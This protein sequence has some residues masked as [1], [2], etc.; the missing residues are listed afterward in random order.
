[1]TLKEYYTPESVEE[2]LGLKA[3]HGTE[4]S[5]MGGGTIFMHLVNDGYIF[6]EQ[7]MGLRRT[8]M[9]SI[10]ENGKAVIGST[11]TMTQLVNMSDDYNMLR[12]AAWS[13]G[14]WAVRNMGTIG[15]NLFARAPYGDVGVALLAL[16]AEVKVQNAGSERVVSLEAF[17]GGG[18]SLGEDELI[19]EIHVPKQTGNTWYH[20][21][22]RRE[23]NAPSIVTVAAQLKLTSNNKVA[24]AR[25]ALGGADQTPV[26]SKA[27]ENALTGNTLNDATIASAAEA[28]AEAANPVEDA[29]ASAWYRRRM[30]HVQLK[31]ALESIGG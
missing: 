23:A 20:K 31:R 25:I 17:Y 2:A 19:T 30:I 24:E 4:L 10:H 12:H 3:E 29:V 26:R 8:G 11:A 13:V 1:V 5:I 14:G 18:R 16:A 6:P 28:A 21:F 15:G 22:G 27:A 7:V 9:N